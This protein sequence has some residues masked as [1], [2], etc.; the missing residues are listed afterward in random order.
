LCLCCVPYNGFVSAPILAIKLYVPPPGPKA[1]PHL[2]LSERLNA[3]LDS[4]LIF[5]PA[6]AG[7]GNATLMSEWAAGCN[8]PLAWLSLD[9]SGNDPARFLS[10]F[11]AALRDG[12]E[13][14]AG[15]A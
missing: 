8:R 9:V 7:L 2:R 6:A 1:V 13:N 11:V 12:S 10:C 4:K 14:V 15:D 5:I 3:G